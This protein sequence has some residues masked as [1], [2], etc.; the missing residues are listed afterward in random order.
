MQAS[1]DN[2]DLARISGV[3]PK[4]VSTLVWA[5]AGLL[6][7]VSVMLIAGQAGTAGTLTEL[8][9]D[10]LVRALAP[11]SSAGLRSFRWT[12]IA[13][14]AIG[15]AESIIGFNYLDQPGLIDALILIA[16]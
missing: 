1:A 13:A 2:P 14:V 6:S 9:P 12:V 11:P 3:N 16:V 4:L 10:T 8:G 15:V 7:T 5:I